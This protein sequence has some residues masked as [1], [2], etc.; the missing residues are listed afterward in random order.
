[1]GAIFPQPRRTHLPIHQVFRLS[2]SF[3]YSL[4]S[5]SKHKNRNKP[6]TQPSNFLS[7]ANARSETK[8]K[9]K[10]VYYISIDL[11]L[12]DR[13]IFKQFRGL[14]PS[15]TQNAINTTTRIIFSLKQAIKSQ[16][17][18]YLFQFDIFANANNYSAYRKGRQFTHT[19]VTPGAHAWA[20]APA[21][22]PGHQVDLIPDQL[23][24]QSKKK[25]NARKQQNQSS[26]KVF[27]F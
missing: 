7:K 8:Q 11:D 16:A 9:T 5:K 1:M 15:P 18:F 24:W 14:A 19:N 25:K 27:K 22:T 2:R 23:A 6:Q 12:K 17:R 4:H 3:L 21:P 10:D 13:P 20:L 26:T